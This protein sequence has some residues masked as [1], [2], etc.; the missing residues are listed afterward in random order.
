MNIVKFLTPLL[1]ALVLVSGC[2]QQSQIEPAFPDREIVFVVPPATSA[3]TTLG[4]VHPDGSGLVTQTFNLGSY[5]RWP[6]WHP[7]S[8]ALAFRGERIIGGYFAPLRAYLLAADGKLNGGCREWEWAFGRVQITP[9]G[10]L[11]MTLQLAGESRQR[12]VLADPYSCTVLD[13]LFTASTDKDTE[14]L[15]SASLSSQG[16]LAVGRLWPQHTRVEMRTLK[17]VLPAKAEVL[18]IKPGAQEPQILGQGLAPAW[19]RD[20]E[21]LAYTALDGIYVVRQDGGASRQVL[22]MNLEVSDGRSGLGWSGDLP[23]ASWSPDN[24]YLIYSRLTDKG[25]A[26]FKV[27]VETGAEIEILNG[28]LDPSWR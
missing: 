24:R 22:Q 3:N 20:G 10:K 4:F 19:S 11:L 9:D 2:N 6:T 16:W 23:I 18:V 5:I 15:E 17:Q 25:P 8:E 21:W 12:I 7:A 26:I 14:W 13:T 27:D 28:G 1:L